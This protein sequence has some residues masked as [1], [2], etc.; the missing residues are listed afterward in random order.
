MVNTQIESFAGLDHGIRSKD[1][2]NVG[3]GTSKTM[4]GI[5]FN[6]MFKFS[7]ELEVV[8]SYFT[9][10]ESTSLWEDAVAN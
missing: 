1:A 5:V 3:E 9:L 7:K 8:F 6:L 10:M 2:K 4:G